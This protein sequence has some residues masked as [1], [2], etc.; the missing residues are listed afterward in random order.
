MTELYLGE[1]NLNQWP[2]EVW[3]EDMGMFKDQCNGERI[4]MGKIA[5]LRRGV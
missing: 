5:A 4:F 3:K 1:I 2:R